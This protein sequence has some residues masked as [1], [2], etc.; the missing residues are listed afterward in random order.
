MVNKVVEIVQERQDMAASLRVRGREGRGRLADVE[1][2]AGRVLAAVRLLAA[3]T[4]PCTVW[5]CTAAVTGL[6]V[7]KA[8]VSAATSPLLSKRPVLRV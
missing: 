3:G 8:A 2:A 1:G 7:C 5:G 6:C 4:A